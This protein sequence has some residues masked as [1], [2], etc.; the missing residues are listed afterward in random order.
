MGYKKQFEENKKK[1]FFFLLLVFGE[2]R[3]FPHPIK[4]LSALY[5]Y[6]LLINE[7]K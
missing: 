5:K 7:A 3:H 2:K 4:N 6:Y 1:G